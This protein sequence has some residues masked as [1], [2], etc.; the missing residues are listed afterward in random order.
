MLVSQ[1]YTHVNYALRGTDDDAPNHGTEEALQ[2]I[3]TLN[4]KKNELYED[5]TKTWGATYAE[6]SLGNITASANPS[7]A[8]PANFIAPSN[9][10]YIIQTDGQRVDIDFIKPKERTSSRRVFVAG[11]DP[12]TLYFTT[13][14]TAG[15]SIVGGELFIQGYFMPADVEDETDTIPLPDPYWGVMSVASEVASNDLSYEDKE[16]GLNAKANNL[17]RQMVRKNKRGTFGDPRITPYAPN[18]LS[19]LELR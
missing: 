7:F 1:F 9:S 14:I 17:Y 12:Q 6:Q 11:L 4:R 10:V 13:A 15:E 16:A 2:W 19:N 8:L 18:P 3:A 5:V